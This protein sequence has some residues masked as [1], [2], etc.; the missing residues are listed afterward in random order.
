VKRKYQ[1]QKQN[2]HGIPEIGGCREEFA[3]RKQN[4]NPQYYGNKEKIKLFAIISLEG[5]KAGN[6]RVAF[7]ISHSKDGRDANGNQ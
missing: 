2:T 3:V 7:P 1:E 6:N 5:K 4:K